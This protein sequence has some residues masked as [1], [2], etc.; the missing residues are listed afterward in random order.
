[1]GFLA[2]AMLNAAT[3]LL[4]LFLMLWS[5]PVMELPS[6]SV[7]TS[8]VFAREAVLLSVRILPPFHVDMLTFL[9]DILWFRA[10]VGARMM[11]EPLGGVRV[12]LNCFT[13]SPLTLINP[14]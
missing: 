3:S 4:L 11:V 6:E 13:S 9:K 2:K 7:R 12:S 5:V 8:L 14:T 1:M 10:G